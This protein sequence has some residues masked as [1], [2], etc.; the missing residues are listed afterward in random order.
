MKGIA[1]H[2]WMPDPLDFVQE[3]TIQLNTITV[4]SQQRLQQLRT[5]KIG[6][7]LVVTMIV[8]ATGN[9]IPFLMVLVAPSVVTFNAAM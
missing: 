6:G 3:E 4:D 1:G 7:L 5:D 2:Y 8:T 9:G